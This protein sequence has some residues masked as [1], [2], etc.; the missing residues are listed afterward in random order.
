MLEG[1][2][3]SEDG[4]EIHAGKPATLT[5]GQT[6]CRIIY[7]FPH[8]LSLGTHILSS[9]LAPYVKQHSG[10]LSARFGYFYTLPGVSYS[11]ISLPGSFEVSQC[12][13]YS[14]F[15]QV[16][17]HCGFT[18]MR[19]LPLCSVTRCFTSEVF[20]GFLPGRCFQAGSCS[21]VPCFPASCQQV[22]VL[23]FPF[24]SLYCSRWKRA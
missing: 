1:E 13:G 14:R 16:Q 18:R 7:F 21:N 11:S 15:E 12:T 3:H 2:I 19:F 17:P 20:V 4:L 8:H 22:P 10:C 9:R 5:Q 23:F 24:E 6:H